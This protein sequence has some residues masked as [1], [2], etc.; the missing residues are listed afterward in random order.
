VHYKP[1][2]LLAAFRQEGCRVA[3]RLYG[4]LLTLPLHP[5]VTPQDVDRI[6]ALLGET[7]AR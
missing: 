3:E 6:A 7:L 5:A 1:N 4:E 2:H